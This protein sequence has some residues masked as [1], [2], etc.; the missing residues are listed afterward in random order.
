MSTR[1]PAPPVIPREAVRDQR[2]AWLWLLSYPVAFVAATL[3]AGGIAGLLG[4]ES[5]SEE[6]APWHVLLLAGVPGVL[7]LLLPG[8]LAWRLGRRAVR[9]GAPNGMVPAVIG[10]TLGVLFVG[11][12]LVSVV[13]S[14][15]L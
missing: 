1:V 8:L 2:R 6:M 11:L 4:Y 14:L 10:A 3:V 12:N 5:G 9:E 13:T 7:L 15:L